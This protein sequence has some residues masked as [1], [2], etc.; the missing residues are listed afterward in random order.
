MQ[1]VST[2]SECVP[3]YSRPLGTRVEVRGN[4][5]GH[6]DEQH[7][8]ALARRLRNVVERKQLGDV[9]LDLSGVRSVTTGFTKLFE[10][11]QACLCQ[12]ERHVVLCCSHGLSLQLDMDGIYRGLFVRVSPHF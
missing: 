2:D 11:F 5:H 6:L 7:L 8:K 10:S 1:R 3:T 9:M 4:A 12:Q